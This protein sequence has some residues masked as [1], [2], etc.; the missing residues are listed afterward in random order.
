M[1]KSKKSRNLLC[2]L[3]NFE[4]TR[5]SG[6]HHD[7]VR[8]RT[9]D[10]NWELW[11]RDD[12]LQYGLWLQMVKD[13]SMHVWLQM[14]CV[15]FYYITSLPQDKE[16]VKAVFT[17]LNDLMQRI[18][19]RQLEHTQEESDEA[20]EEMAVFQQIYSILQQAE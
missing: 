6:K 8:I 1:F 17:S 18:Q 11:H 9:S 10:G 16:S 7:Y 20:V 14:L 3:G 2:R 5:E 12:A 15:M 19:A 13:E 4:V